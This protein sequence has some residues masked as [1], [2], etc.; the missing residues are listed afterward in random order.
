MEFVQGRSLYNY[1]RSRIS[2]MTDL[3]E[4]EEHVKNIVRQVVSGIRCEK[5][6]LA[7]LPEQKYISYV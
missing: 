7:Q 1:M 3:E 5:Y 4:K 6:Y 2:T